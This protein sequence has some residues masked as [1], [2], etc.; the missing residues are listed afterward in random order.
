MY[1]IPKVANGPPSGSVQ[2]H[3][4]LHKSREPHAEGL[5]PITIVGHHD[6]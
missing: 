6:P 2:F 5:C 4:T 1:D 3:H